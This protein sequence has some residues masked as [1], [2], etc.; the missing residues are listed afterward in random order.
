[1]P[2]RTF[3][4]EDGK[5]KLGT[6]TPA[7][8]LRQIEANSFA[9]LKSFCYIVPPGDPDEGDVYVIPG[10]DF[11]SSAA[12]GEVTAD[13]P[14]GVTPPRVVIPPDTGG[15]TDLASVP[16]MLWWLIASYGNHTRAALLH[17]ALYVDEGEPPVPRRTADRLFLT[18][19]R[20]PGEPKAGPF[21]HWLMWAAVS[22]FGTMRYR[23]GALFGAHVLAVWGLT[24]GAVVWALGDGI[25]WISWT[26]WQ[27]VL[28]IVVALAFLVLIGT[29]WRAGVDL[30]GGWLVPTLLGTAIVLVPL[31]IEWTYPFEFEL[32]PFML[33]VGALAL[34]LFG[35][36]WGLWVD[37][38]LRGWLWPT[39]LIG[40]PI[41]VIPVILILVAIRLVWLIDL[42]AA[43]AVALRR[44]KAGQGQGFQVPTIKQ[45]RVRV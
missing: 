15:L 45:T 4:I 7:P 3:R 40:L 28:A 10:A 12:T 8:E 42:G 29:S 35:P 32:S 17:D 30:T 25:V 22:A 44:K 19:L 27:I 18:A 21:R 13:G 36:L 6:S 23:L 34:T 2:F 5:L 9:I 33:L 24:I 11:D 14:D 41:A 1:V 43:I 26:W 38:T 37:P 20:E 39:A 31:A 16:P